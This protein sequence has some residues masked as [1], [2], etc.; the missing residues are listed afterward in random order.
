M[1]KGMCIDL[2]IRVLMA[3]NE[4]Y[5]EG[6]FLGDKYEYEEGQ[7]MNEKGQSLI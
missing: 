7:S 2:I 1:K 5:E 4:R 6:S 3:V